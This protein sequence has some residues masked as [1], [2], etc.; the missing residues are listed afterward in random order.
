M[1]ARLAVGVKTASGS[2]R[3]EARTMCL[4][5]SACRLAYPFQGRL[6]RYSC[7][8][9]DARRT[10]KNGGCRLASDACGPRRAT[11]S[12]RA[13][14]PLG[15]ASKKPFAQRTRSRGSSPA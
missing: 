5:R 1:G 15:L 4:T 8:Q 10:W 12:A 2:C 7:Q 6:Q 9:G 14:V 3:I 13:S 11:L